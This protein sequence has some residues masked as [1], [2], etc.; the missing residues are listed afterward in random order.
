[1]WFLF[2]SRR[3]HTR[4]ALG[5]G[6]QTCALPIFDTLSGRPTNMITGTKYGD[7][8]LW[9]YKGDW[10]RDIRNSKYNIQRTYYW[11]NPSSAFYGQPM[12]IDNIGDPS[13]FYVKTMPSFKKGVSAVH[14]GLFTDAS[15]GQNHDNGNIYKEWSIN[16]FAV[17]YLLR[18]EEYFRMGEAQKYAKDNT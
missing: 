8:T 6:V 15:S 7:T 3:R 12:T 14:H 17:V 13:S 5:T 1:M 4:C 16:R 18:G 10:N 11:T 2:S 9:E